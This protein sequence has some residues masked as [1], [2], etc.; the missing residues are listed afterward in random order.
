ML[1]DTK[2]QAWGLAGGGGGLLGLEE[3]STVVARNAR[4]ESLRKLTSL[5]KSRKTRKSR[6]AK[7][8]CRV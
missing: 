8:L 7:V 2:Y 3:G 5:I 6:F 4:T 1:Q